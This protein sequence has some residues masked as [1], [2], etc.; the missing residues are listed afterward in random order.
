MKRLISSLVLAMMACAAV[1]AQRDT[2]SRIS[3][4]I[5]DATKDT[6]IELHQVNYITFKNKDDQMEY[7]KDISRIRV[8]LPYVRASKKLYA[9]LQDEKSND[10]RRGYRHFRKDLEKDMK[11]KFEKELKDLTISQ[12]KVMVKLINRETGNNCYKII[13]DVKGGFSAFTWQIVARHYSYDLKEEYDPH[14]EWI[15]ELA[16]KALG[17]EYD[18]N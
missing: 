10:S 7:W 14:K 3:G 6:T 5:P 11:A 17:P 4:M 16:I 2:T 13:K 18:P 1:A 8:V 12:G 9:Q 15:L